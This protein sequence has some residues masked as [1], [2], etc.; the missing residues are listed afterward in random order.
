LTSLYSNSHKFLRY[1]RFVAFPATLSTYLL[2]SD[3]LLSFVRALKA[4]S[5]REVDFWVVH[6]AKLGFMVYF[7]IAHMGCNEKGHIA[8]PL[9]VNQNYPF[10]LSYFV[11][12]LY[13]IN[14][15]LLPTSKKN[16]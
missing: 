4:L 2:D 11:P 15:L 6:V 5:I 1:Q 8:V 3:I 9:K 14:I 7:S 16:Q 10:S 12:I 13:S